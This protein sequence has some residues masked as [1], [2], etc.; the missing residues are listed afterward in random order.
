MVTTRLG[1]S[2]ELGAFLAGVLLSS[3]EQQEAV[4]AAVQPASYLFLALFVAST[5]LTIP[6]SFL[7]EHFLV[8]TAGTLTIVIA[9]S[10]LFA[11][12]VTV[13]RYPLDV[14]LAVGLNMAQVGEFGFVLLSLANRYNLVGS[15]VYLLLMGGYSVAVG[16]AFI[17]RPPV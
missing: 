16:F 5:G 10:L 1:I 11:G 3:T 12:V 15:Q 17:Y 13:F 4:L 7:A 2:G 14:S 8:L 9:K 6:P